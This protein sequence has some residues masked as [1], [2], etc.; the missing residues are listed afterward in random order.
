[1]F[2][3]PGIFGWV[4]EPDAE[5]FRVLSPNV[6]LLERMADQSGGEL[7]PADG[8]DQFVG[9]LSRRKV[10]IVEPW[11]YPLWHQWTVFAFAIACLVGEWGLRRWR[12]LP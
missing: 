10:P 1:M 7:V 3:I 4:A 8:L 6:A 11:V 2:S 5:E 9:S 12:G